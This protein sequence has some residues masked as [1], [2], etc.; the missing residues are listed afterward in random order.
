[1]R[2]LDL[3]SDGSVDET[4]IDEGAID[5]TVMDEGEMDETAIDEAI[6][7]LIDEAI[8]EAMLDGT[9]T[10]DH[11]LEVW[12]VEEKARAAMRKRREAPSSSKHRG[13][14]ERRAVQATPTTRQPPPRK[15]GGGGASSTPIW[16]AVTSACAPGS[17]TVEPT[18]RAV[19]S[20]VSRASE[21]QRRGASGAAAVAAAKAK[22]AAAKAGAKAAAASKAAAARS[23]ATR[24]SSASGSA[25][26][27]PRTADGAAVA[28]AK[29]QPPGEAV[30]GTAASAGEEGR[31]S[32]KEASLTFCASPAAN[33]SHLRVAVAQHEADSL[34]ERRK[35]WYKPVAM[36][37]GIAYSIAEGEALPFKLGKRMLA[38]NSGAA[39]NARAMGGFV[40]YDCAARAL[41]AALV[42]PKGKLAHASKAVLRVTASRECA[43]AHSRWPTEGGVWAFEMIMPTSIALEQQTWMEDRAL[44][45]LWLPGAPSGMCKQCALGERTCV[46]VRSHLEMGAPPPKKAP[47][48]PKSKG[49]AAAGATAACAKAAVSPGGSKGGSTTFSASLEAASFDP[50]NAPPSDGQWACASLPGEPAANCDFRGYL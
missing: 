27:T 43:P 37:G 3:L 31:A 21:A 17:A 25:A 50:L 30:E 6:D 19:S 5:E 16:Q 2:R 11:M 12:E 4:A 13:S 34:F 24:G 39:P 28:K 33:L 42:R 18:P 29:A 45:S 36:L 8:D 35:Y 7:D 9:F 41:Q 49:G 48:T 14:S 20:R 44:A 32:G 10:E 22:E 23:S 46:Q 40:V 15:S 47:Q 1:M 26:A 38:A